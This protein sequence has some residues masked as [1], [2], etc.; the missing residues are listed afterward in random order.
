MGMVLALGYL[1]NIIPKLDVEIVHIFVSL[2]SL[3]AI[4]VMLLV[5]TPHRPTKG[6]LMEDSLNIWLFGLLTVFQCWV[7]FPIFF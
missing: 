5:I 4:L 6:V 7:L 1:E 2:I 3:S